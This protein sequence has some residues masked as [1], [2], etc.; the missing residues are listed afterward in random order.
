MLGCWDAGMLEHEAGDQRV[1]HRSYRIV[2]ATVTAP[3]FE[4]LHKRLIGEGVEHQAQ[5]FEI[6]QLVDAVPAEQKRMWYSGHRR[7]SCCELLFT[8]HYGELQESRQLF[9]I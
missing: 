7:F 2:V 3:G 5:A 9:C 8:G 1:P 4:Q 6:T